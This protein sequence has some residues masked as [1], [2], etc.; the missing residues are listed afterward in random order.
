[1]INLSLRTYIINDSSAHKLIA[2]SIQQDLKAAGITITIETED[3]NVFLQDRKDGNYDFAREGWVA[4]YNDPINMLEMFTSD[5]GNND[6]QFGGGSDGVKSDSAPDWT[7]YDALIDE[8]RTTTDF[9]KRVDLMHQA[10]DMLMSTYA[11]IP[12]YYYNDVYMCKSNVTGIF[13]TV[14]GMKYFM[15]ADVQ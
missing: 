14:F 10:E 4:D 2:E 13:S 15:Y 7:E 9:A 11:V 5:S 3:W 8:I 1:M 12:I 6:P